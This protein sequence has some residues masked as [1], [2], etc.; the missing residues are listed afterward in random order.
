MRQQLLILF[1]FPVL[2]L[3][4][5]ACA[6]KPQE[7]CGYVQNP[8]GQRISWKG[9]VPVNVQIHESVPAEFY[10]AIR[11]AVDAWGKASGKPLFRIVSTAY[12]DSG[13]PQVDGVNVVYWMRDWEA[14]RAQEQARTIVNYSGDSITDADIRINAKDFSFYTD[15]P[16]MA[17]DI[18]FESLVK[19]ELGHVL[20]RKHQ[21]NEGSVMATVLPSQTVRTSL[22][23]GDLKALRCEY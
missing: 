22:S 10:P 11:S 14:N 21:D 9:R 20:G 17:R 6:P 18:H 19:H 16:K 4:L 3:A 13:A 5:Q 12:R 23:D 1:M 2:I 8:Q 7:D 15:R